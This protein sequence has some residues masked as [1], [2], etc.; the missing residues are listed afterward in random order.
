MQSMLTLIDCIQFH[1]SHN[2]VLVALIAQFLAMVTRVTQAVVPS[3]TFPTNDWECSPS[4][5]FSIKEKHEYGH[6]VDILVAKNI[7]RHKACSTHGL[8]PIY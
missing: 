5:T 7:S 2:L 3:P 8:H 4:K 6:A 1:L